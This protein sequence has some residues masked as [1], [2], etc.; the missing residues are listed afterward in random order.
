MTDSVPVHR[1]LGATSLRSRVAVLAALVVIL[2]VVSGVAFV[3]VA[4]NTEAAVTRQNQRRLA[5]LAA[6][7]AHDYETRAPSHTRGL[8]LNEPSNPQSDE[9]LAAISGAALVHEAG[10][11]GGFY[12]RA[13]DRL[14]GYAF[15]THEGPTPKRDIPPIERP[16]IE[17]VARR[18]VQDLEPSASVF[19]GPRDVI[20]FEAAPVLVNG[21]GA[22]SAWVMKRLPEVRSE[23]A[24]P[25][26]LGVAAFVAAS[27]L[28]VGL[29]YVLARGVSQGVVRIED[30]LH[31]LERDIATPAAPGFGGLQEL[32]RIHHG[33][34]Q[35][36][37][38][39]RDRMET[40]RELRHTLEHK[41]R[42]AA[43]GQVAAGVA[44][45]LRNPLAT[46]RL[47]TQMVGRASTDPDVQRSVTMM[48]QEIARLD[49]MV[50]RLLSF[51]RPIALRLLTIDAADLVATSLAA[52][53]DTARQS[54]VTVHAPP[55]PPGLRL[56]CDP[57]RLRQVLDNVLQNAVEATPVG[58]RVTV[59]IHAADGEV[60]I[61][62]SDQGTGVT[63]A[64]A[65]RV[66]DPFFTTKPS[67]TGLG[68]SIAY[69][70]VR[71]HEG[72]LEIG[73]GPSAG[74]TV[75]IALVASG[76]RENGAVGAMAA[77]DV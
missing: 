58:G 28:C 77:V 49:D 3:V 2:T 35:L 76:P 17:D 54:G 44:H 72:R 67:G 9:I 55:G 73:N 29:A 23:L 68:L 56:V 34:N 70:I 38:S 62:V 69:E 30:R 61:S 60:V 47:R 22:G 25:F 15:P 42:L 64:V 4:T 31:D 74:A 65:A 11:E 6:T 59:T 50:E 18:A 21:T 12:S 75:S 66:F 26:N 46:I 16:I 27:L 43:V 57:D 14:M 20:L 37:A 24:T 33:I 36:A 45:E 41:E 7:L 40:E 32:A 8:S 10:V 19:R 63:D 51:S 48:L 13:T 52:I 53:A 39:L 1:V 71:A 5:A